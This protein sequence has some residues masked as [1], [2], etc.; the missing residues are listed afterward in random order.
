MLAQGAALPVDEDAPAPQSGPGTWHAP[1][2]KPKLNRKDTHHKKV[3]QF[4]RVTH[5]LL[6][7]DDVA[8][9]GHDPIDLRA[10]IGE[11]VARRDG[12]QS[13]R[14]SIG[15]ARWAR[16]VLRLDCNGVAH[17]AEQNRKHH[18]QRQPCQSKTRPPMMP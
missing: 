8:H 18:Q 6:R 4:A 16:F 11:V 3:S 15:V 12:Q 14:F 17:H 1:K 5:P 13:P 10:F 2:N 9:D 7:A